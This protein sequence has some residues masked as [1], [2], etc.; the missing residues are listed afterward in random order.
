MD[1]DGKLE[2]GSE[3]RFLFHLFYYITFF[4]LSKSIGI[5]KSIFGKSIG[6]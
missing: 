2:T 4:V 5:F 6:M 1:P 3:K